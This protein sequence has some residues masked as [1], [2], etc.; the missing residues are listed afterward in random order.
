MGDAHGGTPAAKDR[1]GPILER[2]RRE[3]ARRWRHLGIHDPRG[4]RGPD[5]GDAAVAALRRPAGAPPRV[6]AEVKHRSPSAGVIRPW[7]AGQGTAIALDYQAAGAAAVSVLCDRVGFGGSV[8]E[9]RRVAAAVRVPVLFKEFVL[10]PLQLDLAR[11]A[12]ASLVLLLVRALDDAA[13][14]ALVRGC[15]DRGLEPVVEAADEGEVER[16]L[17]TDARIVGVNARDLSSFRVDPAAAARA[18][19]KIPA[20][21]VAVYMSGVSSPEQLVEVAA[22]RADAVL[23]G[24]ALMAAPDPGRRLSELLSGGDVEGRGDA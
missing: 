2:K 20:S 15:R 16:A 17:R 13:L 21:R 11:C 23:V 3:N 18:V 22:T 8:L 6:I 7:A 10:D 12:G 24:S 1:L 9:L 14:G 4:A 19:E 5:R